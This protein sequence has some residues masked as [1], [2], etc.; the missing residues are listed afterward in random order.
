MESRHDRRRAG[1]AERMSFKVEP[2]FE[3]YIGDD[4]P[5]RTM[6]EA[7]AKVLREWWES[8]VKNEEDP[9]E[10]APELC[11]RIFVAMTSPIFIRNR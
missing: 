3:H 6:M 2:P 7:G 8:P 1:D 10:D 5:D 11:R 4:Y 9:L